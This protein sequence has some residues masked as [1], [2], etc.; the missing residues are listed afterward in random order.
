MDGRGKADPQEIWY[1]HPHDPFRIRE[2]RDHCPDERAEDKED[3]DT[4]EREIFESKLDPG[5]ESIENEVQDKWQQH[6][7]RYLLPEKQLH[8]SPERNSDQ[9]VQY[10]PY[11]SEHPTWRRPGRLH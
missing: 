9:Y 11:R 5:K 3:I 2:Y 10:G 8:H 4:C 6:H 1:L 7:K